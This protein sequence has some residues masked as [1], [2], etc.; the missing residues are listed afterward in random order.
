MLKSFSVLNSDRINKYGTLFTLSAMED[1][2][3]MKSTEGVPMHLGHD[4]HRPIGLMIPFGL[5]FEPNLVRNI[6]L[7]LIPE[8]D[9]ENKQI[10]DFKNYSNYKNIKESIE[11]NDEKLFK[12]IEKHIVSDYKYIETGTLAVVN[13]NI[14]ERFFGE[15]SS[16]KD[17]NGLIKIKDLIKDFTYKYQGVFFHNTLPLCIYA[18]S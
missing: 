17:K 7:S 3:W 13:K 5:Y 10:L 2:V 11:E 1:M 9:K 8:T 4:M 12:E 6:G 16:N 14:V 15:L 18:H